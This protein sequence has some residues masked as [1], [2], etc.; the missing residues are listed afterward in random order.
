MRQV[1]MDDKCLYYYDR[2]CCL[3]DSTFGIIPMYHAA[4]CLPA[5]QT[6][7]C[8]TCLVLPLYACHT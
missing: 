1:E 3:L 8:E 4:A 2:L 6:F 5:L 7:L